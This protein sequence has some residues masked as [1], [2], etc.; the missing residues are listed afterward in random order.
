MK[1]I[2]YDD[3]DDATSPRHSSGESTIMR[4]HFE[5][6]QTVLNFTLITAEFIVVSRQDIVF[7]LKMSNTWIESFEKAGVR[8]QGAE[9]PI[10]P[11]GPMPSEPEEKEELIMEGW[12]EKQGRI[13]TF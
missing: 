10:R 7:S 12:V 9:L 8:R 13:N 6:G 5:H 2:S 1:E 3:D 11:P 4:Y